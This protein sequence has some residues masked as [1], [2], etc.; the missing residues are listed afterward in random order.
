MRCVLFILA[1]LAALSC[2]A[3]EGRIATDQLPSLVLLPADLPSF[4]QFAQGPQVAADAHAGPRKDPARFGRLGGWIARYRPADAAVRNGPLVVE[5][6]ADLFPS[7]SAAKQDLEAYKAEYATTVA[8]FGGKQLGSVNVGDEAHAFT[9]GGGA[10]FFYVIAWRTANGT[11]SV[12]V[13]GSVVT[14][15][16]ALALARKQSAR[17]SAASR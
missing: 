13:E 1:A 17:L 10:D 5:S 16:D 3:V 12:L 11:A 14:L 4:S 9:F 8:G 7:T 15:D 2:D 6:R